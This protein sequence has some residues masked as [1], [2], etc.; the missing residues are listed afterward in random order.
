MVLHHIYYPVQDKT[1]AIIG[2]AIFAQDITERKHMEEEVRR[3]VEELERFRK[4]AIG[5]EI[6][7]I[8]LKE[9]INELLNQSGQGEKYEIVE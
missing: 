6:K 5:R 7:M 4:M 9:E 1:G 3:N 8:Q 2:V